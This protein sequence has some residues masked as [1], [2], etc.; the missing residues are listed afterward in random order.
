[1]TQVTDVALDASGTWS[2]LFA[3]EISL[4]NARRDERSHQVARHVL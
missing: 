1:M 2:L 4:I 3:R